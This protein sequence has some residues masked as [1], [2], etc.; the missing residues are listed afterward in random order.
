L[1]SEEIEQLLTSSMSEPPLRELFR[2][3]LRRWLS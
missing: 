2:R 1:S 3:R